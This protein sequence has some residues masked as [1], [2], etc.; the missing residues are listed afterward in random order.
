MQS[1]ETLRNSLGLNY[2]SE[3]LFVVNT[4]FLMNCETRQKK[5]RNCCGVDARTLIPWQVRATASW[6]LWD[7]IAMSSRECAWSIYAQP[8]TVNA[9]TISDSSDCVIAETQ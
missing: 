6:T 4:S 1:S 2:K 5:L 3:L 9:Q 8:N 7:A